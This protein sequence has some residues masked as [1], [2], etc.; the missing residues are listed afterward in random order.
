LS[1][2]IISAA[3]LPELTIASTTAIDRDS[4][5][6]GAMRAAPA[7]VDRRERLL[8]VGADFVRKPFGVYQD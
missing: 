4:T 7:T 8:I 1:V 5:I 6:N 2:T 3:A